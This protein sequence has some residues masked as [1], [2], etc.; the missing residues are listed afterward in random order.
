MRRAFYY[1]IAL[2]LLGLIALAMF[3][4]FLYREL[5]PEYR[6]YQNDYV[7]IEKFR[8]SYTHEPHPSFEKGIKQIVI[9]REDRGPPIIDRCVSCHVALQYSHF[10]PTKISRDPDG[11]IQKDAEGNPIQVPNEEYIW[12][13]LD[14]KIAALRDEKVIAQLREEK[15]DSLISQHL[16]EADQLEALKT[17]HV[18]DNVYDVT[19]VLRMHPLIGQETRPFE[20]HPIEEYGCVSCHNGNGRGLTTER[21]HGPVFDGQYEAEFMGYKPLFTE[22]DP[23]NDPPFS[24]AFNEKPG[25]ELLFQTTPLFVGALIQAKCAD[26]HQAP[27]PLFDIKKNSTSSISQIDALTKNFKTGQDLFI[28][29]ACYACHRI[30]GLSRGGIGPELTK[31]GNHYPWFIKE[32]L[33]WPQ[34]DLKTSTMPNYHMDHDELEDLV[35]FLL[36]QT[37]S[38]RIISPEA[39]RQTVKSWEEGKKLSW[40]KPATPAQIHDL[41]YSMTVFAAEGCAAC[42]RLQGYDSNIGYAV[43]QENADFNTLN[44]EKVWFKTLFPENILG[45]NLVEVIEKNQNEIDK[46]IVDGIRAH[47]I[48]EEIEQNNPGLIASFYTP[49]K[50]AMRAKNDYYKNLIEHE[51]DPSKIKEYQSSFKLWKDRVRKIL[52]IFVQEYGLGRLIC[53]RPNWAGVYR[54]DEWLIE[55]FRNPTSHVPNS[56]MP[57]F[58]FDDSKFYALTFM[59]DKLGI[60]NRDHLHEI[61]GNKGFNPELAFEQL[62]SQCHGENR[63]GN[64]P[65]SEW[66]YPLPKNLRNADFL[67][68]LTKERAIQ[69][70]THGVKGTPMPP[71]GEIHGDKSNGG[72]PILNESEISQL[73]DW[74]FS[75]LAGSHSFG[76]DAGVPKWHYRPED[77]LK[78]LRDEGNTLNAIPKKKPYFA[79]LQP[80]VAGQENAL[81]ISD[82]FD[83]VPSPVPGVEDKGFYLKHK[84]Y[85]E[86]NI[87]AGKTF[88]EINCAPCHGKEADGTGLRAAVMQEAKPRML[89]NLDWINTRDDLRLLRSI[90][91]GVPGTSMTPWGDFTSALQRMQLVVF[92]RSLT[93]NVQKR[94]MIL[95]ALYQSFDRAKFLIDKS[96]INEYTIVDKLQKEYEAVKAKRIAEY[97]KLE[98]G[99]ADTALAEK[100][101]SQEIDLLEKVNEEKEKDL[102]FIE[103][104]KLVDQEHN[105]FRDLGFRFLAKNLDDAILQDYT[106]LIS[107]NDRWQNRDNKLILD[108]SEKNEEQKLQLIEKISISLKE[109][110]RKHVEL[111]DALESQPRSQEKTEKIKVLNADIEG[112]N[113][114]L[115]LFIKDMETIQQIQEKE[116]ELYKRE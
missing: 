107:L 110:I 55:H 61:W 62:C 10:S 47:G 100:L 113:K 91:F 82:L 77:F 76:E 13:K 9:E 105:L 39:Y 104:K 87:E 70:I 6:I 36:A 17:A 71:W 46:R 43:E 11:N 26:C 106:T 32:S 72:K 97:Q 66:I 16:K 57:V 103:L 1:Q 53:P 48:L 75:S 112:L 25:S 14:Q 54:S 95:N 24:R 28:S 34:A 4:A 29:Q 80:T 81:S 31:E 65:V 89:T 38:S 42:H 18:D 116:T 33:V 96:R 22:S 94:E 88:F 21:A 30:S 5:F 79:S 51:T 52:M 73:V 74:L 50:Y 115:E 92:I 83:V 102:K 101:Y 58:P 114:L 60:I 2:I 15:Q 93:G 59:L 44:K 86:K 19:K 85:T 68:N 69:S 37:G 49:F 109:A 99:G 45:S 108:K 111:K 67:R 98:K 20:F 78:E 56:I 7:A 41:R 35:T 63:S 84:F 3:S 40:E 90:K 23:K 27:S 8:S 64:G 12:L